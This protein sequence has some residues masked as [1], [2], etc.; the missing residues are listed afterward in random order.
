[1]FKGHTAEG[2][3]PRPQLVCGGAHCQPCNRQ[4]RDKNS[5]TKVRLQF[6][7]GYLTIY[8][9]HSST[10]FKPLRRN[11][12]TCTVLEQLKQC[13]TWKKER[14]SKI[15][16]IRKQTYG[17]NDGV[18]VQSQSSRN[19][20]VTAATKKRSNLEIELNLN[21]TLWRMKAALNAVCV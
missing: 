2:R 9:A 17:H 13:R 19:R 18:K 3:Q 8:R 7:G 21:K 12:E 4:I 15:V 20:S 5:S 11:S 10:P 6:C 14:K 1:M 16:E